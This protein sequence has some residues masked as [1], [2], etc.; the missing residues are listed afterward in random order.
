MPDAYDYPVRSCFRCF[1]GEFTVKNFVIFVLALSAFCV[2]PHSS[3][4]ADKARQEAVAERGADVMPF[5][6]EATTHIFTKIEMGGIQQVIVKNA[7]DTTQIGL[8]RKHLKKIAAQFSKGDFSD[9]SHI[10]G[11]EMPGLAELKTAQPGEIKIH[12][13]QLK[14][15]AEISYM[16]NNPKLVEALHQW[17]DAQLADHGKD[18]MA[19]HDHSM[20]HPQ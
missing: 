10:H 8:I 11:T 1:I 16:T 9:P 14:K 18:A 19:G 3:F 4:A 2:V 5:D 7:S 6:L 15:G 20:M 13:R 17:F 12:Y